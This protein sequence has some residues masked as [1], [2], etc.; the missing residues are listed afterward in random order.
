MNKMWLTGR[1]T[2][3]IELRYT[4]SSMEV[5]QF[6]LAVTRNFKNSEGEYD[7]DF[8]PVTLWS[9]IA[10]NT[11]N[12]CKKGDLIGV[13][14]KLESSITTD[15]GHTID[16]NKRL[17]LRVVAEKVTFLSSNKGSDNND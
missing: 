1:I 3:D 14:G 6:S 17:N 7:T 8:I 10:E 5:C 12:Y 9:S 2:K 13:R 16:E 15:D 11:T 4:N